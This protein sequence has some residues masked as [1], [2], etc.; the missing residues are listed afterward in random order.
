MGVSGEGATTASELPAQATSGQA[1]P[2]PGLKEV[3]LG[4]KNR[5]RDPTTAL[6][7]GSLIPRTATQGLLFSYSKLKE[8]ERELNKNSAT[9]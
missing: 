2:S 5:V 4:G 6:T 3:V 8:R 7:H 1:P 9:F